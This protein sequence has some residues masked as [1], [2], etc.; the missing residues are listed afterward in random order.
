[1]ET[2]RALLEDP[3]SGPPQSLTGLRLQDL[4]LHA[5]ESQL[6]ARTDVTGLV[7]LGGRLSPD[8]SLHLVQH[9]AIV[10]PRDPHAPVSVYRSRLYTA[11]ELYAGL[12]SPGGYA[13][14]PDARAHEWTIQAPSGQ[15]A[16]VAMLR[17]IHDESMTDALG[18]AL[19]GLP[20]AGVMGGHSA[21]RGSHVYAAATRLGHTLAETGLVVATGGG[22]G[23]MEAA[24][25]GAYATDAAAMARAVSRLAQV[26]GFRPD[27]GEWARTGLA[28]RDQLCGPEP[29]RPLRSVGIPTWF[30]GHEPPNVFAQ[31][32]AKYFSNALREDGLIARCT[33]GIIVLQ[34][35]AG[36]VQEVFQIATRLFYERV[37]P[38][39]TAARRVDESVGQVNGGPHRDGPL[40][41]LVLVGIDYWNRVLP[42]WPLLL[43]LGAD[44]PMGEVIHLVDTVEE[45]AE[46]VTG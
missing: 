22:P 16:Y 29:D 10:F 36:T 8:L 6:L 3:G 17:A 5:V 42:A 39:G 7:V 46:L 15:D 13:G 37:G 20:V 30:Y 4:D 32:V 23:A 40:P 14:T 28:I 43:T 24:N 12:S 34:G 41:P 45:A 35:A 18:E 1:M 38:G 25:L 26:P 11:D 2:L 31:G 21:Q 33:A 19:A 9:G 27:V 44:R